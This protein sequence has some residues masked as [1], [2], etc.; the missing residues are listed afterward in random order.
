MTRPEKQKAVKGKQV[1]T[2]Q[3]SAHQPAN[4]AEDGHIGA[5]ENEVAST[6]AP[7]GSAFEDEPKQG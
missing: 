7:S 1:P 2:D 4:Q 5:T 3:S 6:P